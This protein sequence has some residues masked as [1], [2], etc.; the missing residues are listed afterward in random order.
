MLK[1][2]A[3]R[4]AEVPLYLKTCNLAYRVFRN[5]GSQVYLKLVSILL[6]ILLLENYTL[7]RKR[8]P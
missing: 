6:E 7:S 1:L 8:S 5:P 4:K 2:R 3:V